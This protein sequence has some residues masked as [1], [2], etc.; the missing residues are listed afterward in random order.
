ME[1]LLLP[2]Y[3]LSYEIIY[4]QVI[5]ISRLFSQKQ[6]TVKWG[7][8]KLYLCQTDTIS[9]DEDL[10]YLPA[11]MELPLHIMLSAC[12]RPGRNKQEGVGECNLVN[13][14]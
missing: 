1:R 2:I 3:I 10:G 4:I 12:L 13:S 6:A 14:R 11:T 7:R 9:I 5:C 8:E